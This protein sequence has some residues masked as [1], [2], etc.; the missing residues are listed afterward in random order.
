[1]DEKRLLAPRKAKISYGNREI[2]YITATAPY[3]ELKMEVEYRNGIRHVK[4]ITPD[5][6][7]K[8]EV[9][10][11]NGTCLCWDTRHINVAFCM[12]WG[13]P[14][15]LDCRYIFAPQEH[16][17]LW[18]LSVEDGSVQWK[19]KSR[20][21]FKHILVN[22]A[23]SICCAVSEHDIVVLDSMTGTEQVRKKVSWINDFKVLGKDKILV[24]ANARQ[25]YILNS[26]TLEIL[27][28][29]HKKE[30]NPENEQA[31]WKRV[32][33]EWKIAEDDNSTI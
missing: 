31:I 19:T 2:R 14:L 18:C 7:V 3:Q 1:M 21:Q 26:E 33:Q 27:E 30:L 16:G 28:I 17:G 25:W 11:R 12:M 6:P 15:S 24:E 5:L 32:F 22:A 9:E 23:G 10:Y 20:A 13:I 8:I 4:V 29:I